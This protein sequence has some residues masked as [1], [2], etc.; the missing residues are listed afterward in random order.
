[1]D[2]LVDS[3]VRQVV[4]ALSAQG[5]TV[6]APAPAGPATAMS[7]AAAPTAPMRAPAGPARPAGSTPAAAGGSASKGVRSPLALAAAVAAGRGDKG[8]KPPTQPQKV[9]ITADMLLRRLTDE[10]GKV[11]E[12]APY[13]FL[14][15]AAMDIIEDRHVPIRRL[16]ECLPKAPGAPGVS[17]APGTCDPQSPAAAPAGASAAATAAPSP[18]CAITAA[19]MAAGTGIGLVLEQ[20]TAPVRTVLTALRQDR[21]AVVDYGQTGCWIANV[22]LLCEAIAAGKIARGVAILPTA[23]EGV[24]LGNKIPGIRAV[25]GTRTDGLA[26]AIRRFAPNLLVLEHTSASYHEMRTMIRAFAA[27]RPP[28]AT[29]KVLMDTLAELE[30]A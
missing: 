2:E 11:L 30:K 6:R 18:P 19:A 27:E 10:G 5:L 26:T 29:A 21:L 4:S 7:A 14:T 24:L 25:Q 1:M 28:R 8:P 23:A 16:A 17:D 22:R 12:L 3:I 13:E 9:F 20:P 15:P